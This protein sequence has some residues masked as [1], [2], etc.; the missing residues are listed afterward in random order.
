MYS[1]KSVK[2]IG[3]VLFFGAFLALSGCMSFQP[4]ELGGALSALAASSGVVTV[5]VK[6]ST[7][8]PLKGASVLFKKSGQPD[9]NWGTTGDDGKLSGRLPV[10]GTWNLEVTYGNTMQS[11][12]VTVGADPV[13][14]TFQTSRITVKLE[15][16]AGVGLAGGKVSSRANVSSGTWFTFG[17]TGPDGTVS[18]EMFPGNWYFSVEYQQTMTSMQQDVAANPVVTF[19]TTKVTLYHSGT[20]RYRGNPSSGTFFTFTKPSMEMLPGTIRFDFSG[21]GEIPITV[22]GCEYKGAVVV[23]ELKDS[24]GNPLPGAKVM[25]KGGPVSPGTW[26][27]F[28]TTDANGRVVGL[29]PPNYNY[30]FEVQYNMTS[31]QQ[32]GYVPTTLKYSFQ[33]KKITV[34]LQTCQGN[35]L[36]GG[37]VQYRGSISSG[38]WFSFGKT[39]ADGTV[40]K[41]L[42]PGNWWFGVEYKQTYTQKQ[43]D[44]GVDPI[45][46]FTT[47][48]VWSSYTGKIEYKGNPS[49]GTWFAF[50]NPMEM[51]PG[52]ITF[53]F[54]GVIIKTSSI[55]GCSVEISP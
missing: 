6:D 4:G 22:S 3:K 13:T 19:K 10:L 39:S 45:V 54:G 40:S 26:F 38:T 15:T 52:D 50:S 53:R 51:L 1:K 20:I 49:S 23:V 32:S 18:R 31:A 28:G 35:S 33:T 12:A 36:A 29:L 7:G 43:Q 30:S 8:A 25:R 34:K 55:S 14:F 24:A 48:R 42:F 44:V 2:W 16:C 27:T 5:E 37:N 21:I 47:S 46:V 9:Q 11:R 17:T 41:E